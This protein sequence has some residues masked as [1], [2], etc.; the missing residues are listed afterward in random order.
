MKGPGGQ[1]LTSLMQWYIKHLCAFHHGAI[2]F[3]HDHWLYTEQPLALKRDSR[4]WSTQFALSEE[5]YT[6]M[7]YLKWVKEW[8]EDEQYWK[9]NINRT[10]D[11]AAVGATTILREAGKPLACVSRRPAIMVMAVAGTSRWQLPW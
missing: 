11:L 7:Q 9:W 10:E 3:V 1:K 6:K 8:D 2:A 4:L 5:Q